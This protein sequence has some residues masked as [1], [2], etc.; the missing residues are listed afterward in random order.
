MSKINTFFA[1]FLLV[2]LMACGSKHNAPVQV[3][4]Q[5]T[6]V[7]ATNSYLLYDEASKEA[8]LIDPGDTIPALLQHIK[9]EKLQLRYI[10]ITHCHPDHIFGFSTI[11]LREKFPQ[12]KVVYSVEECED[13]FKIVAKWKEA[14]PDAVSEEIQKS[15]EFLK[16]FT[17]DYQRIGKPDIYVEDQQKL[18]LGK[19]EITAIKTPGHARGSVSY[20]VDN[21]LFSGDELIYHAVGGTTSS[22]V[23]SFQTQVKSI[24]KLYSLLP[25]ETI[26]YPGHGRSTTIGE[27]KKHNANI[28]ANRAVQ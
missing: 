14:Y 12:A 3:L 9:K 13:M 17:M 2:F 5:K 10:L 22:P 26:V 1:G 20:Y 21:F 19:A 16:L 23:A 8:A 25:D 11:N 28:S 7:I 6:G 18:P 4:S 15:P 24:R 27:E